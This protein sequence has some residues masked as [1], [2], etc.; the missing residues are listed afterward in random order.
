MRD[1]RYICTIHDSIDT[2]W[3]AQERGPG[4]PG[5]EAAPGARTGRVAVPAGGF[6]AVRLGANATAFWTRYLSRWHAAPAL[7]AARTRA[8]DRHATAWSNVG[9]HPIANRPRGRRERREPLRE[10]RGLSDP[11]LSDAGR[12]LERGARCAAVRL[13]DRRRGLVPV[14]GGLRRSHHGPGAA[15]RLARVRRAR[16]AQAQGHVLRPGPGG[17]DLPTHAPG[18]ARRRA[19]DPVPRLQ[20]PAVVLDG[21]Q[22]AA[23]RAGIRAQDRGGR[24][25]R[26]RHGVP[27]S[28][29]L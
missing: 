15:E 21:P 28:R 20:P 27:R 7:S 29:L 24:V 8:T 2:S 23:H 17:R 3:F 19:R 5:D 13:H 11:A 9:S 22:G 26:A 18:S 10:Q 25:R 16:Q 12:L 14:F 4:G 1:A 6:E